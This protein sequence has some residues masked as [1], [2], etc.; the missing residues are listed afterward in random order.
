MIGKRFGKLTVTAPAGKD[1]QGHL[2][3]KC[4]CDC[5]NEAVVRGTQLRN[6]NTGSCGCARFGSRGTIDGKRPGRATSGKAQA[7]SSTGTPGVNRFRGK[8]RAQ[9]CVG[10]ER[11][12][13]GVFDDIEDAIA[14]RKAAEEEHFGPRRSS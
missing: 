11:M 6:G 10:G 4:L 1:R 7:N 14:A 5:G 2:M 3:W 12:Y 13:L 8:Y 9:I